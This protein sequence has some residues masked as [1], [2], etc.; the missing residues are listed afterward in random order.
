MK[1]EFKYTNK[2][3]LDN[4]FSVIKMFYPIKLEKHVVFGIKIL[5]FLM[6]LKLMMLIVVSS[7]KKYH[8]IWFIYV[9]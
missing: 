8:L 6:H 2:T 7:G 3:E 1:Q 4:N 9:Q 5:L